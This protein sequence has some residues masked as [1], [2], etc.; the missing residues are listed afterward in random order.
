M[1]RLGTIAALLA[2][3]A[4]TA[5]A[6]GGLSSA[7]L[8]ASVGISFPTGALSRTHASGFNLGALAEYEAPGEAMGIRGEFFYERFGGKATVAGAR[9][10]QTTA[11]IIDAIYHV[12]DSAL[13]AYFIGGMGI[14]NVTGS[15]TKPGFNGGLGIRIPLTG[16][17]AYFEARLHTV[18]IDNASYLTLPVSF[19][20]SF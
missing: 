17:T 20:L 3:S 15:G 16:M 14:Y 19:G 8:G 5:L 1:K 18:L 9:S 11:G 10:S 7:H 12:P 4:S 13:H 6:Q 2:F